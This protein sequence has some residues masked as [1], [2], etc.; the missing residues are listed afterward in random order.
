M[1]K[2]ESAKNL[3][4]LMRSIRPFS[5]LR[6][7]DGELRWLLAVEQGDEKL[8]D[9]LPQG[10][11]IGKGAS[12]NVA[13]GVRGLN[14]VDYQRLMT[15]YEKCTYLDLHQNHLYNHKN[16]HKLQLN[17]ASNTY[18]EAPETSALLYT[19]MFYEFGRYI[20]H[21]RCLFASAES[22]LLE[23]LYRDPRYQEIASD[24]WGMNTNPFFIRLRNDGRYYWN[25]LDQIKADLRHEI[26][27]NQIDTLFLA[28]GTGAKILCYE[29]AQEMGIAA[30]D[31]GSGARAMAYSGSYGYQVSRASHNPFLFRVPFPIYMDAVERA[32]PR[33]TTAELLSRAHAQLCLE[34]QRKEVGSSRGVDVFDASSF[35]TSHINLKNF[36]EAYHYYK[37]H[38]RP[39]GAGN[40][41][42]IKL[43]RDFERYR[44]SRGLGIDGRLFLFLSRI[45]HQLKAQIRHFQ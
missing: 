30:F 44:L 29:L 12:V 1:S 8:Q 26:E 23:Q 3:T 20:S 9:P 11:Q 32:Y 5:Y 38:Y 28:L 7:G 27:K 45:K 35:K 43:I 25:H 4:E 16:I 42:A 19:W 6:M 41:E 34:L 31:W 37:Q 10:Y 17:R 22:P 33:M 15:A 24:Y 13:Y 14:T 39:R 18:T 40:A 2:Q 21:R 36:W